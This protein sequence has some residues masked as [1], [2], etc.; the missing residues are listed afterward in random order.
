MNRLIAQCSFMFLVCHVK[1]DIFSKRSKADPIV[2]MVAFIFASTS[3]PTS[4]VDNFDFKTF[5]YSLNPRFAI[6][7]RTRMT[8]DITQL[9]QHCKKVLKKWVLI[10]NGL[11]G[12]SKMDY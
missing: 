12:Q 9:H 11:A 2:K 1:E 5:V 10:N 7:G 3:L 6:P 8:A 4:I